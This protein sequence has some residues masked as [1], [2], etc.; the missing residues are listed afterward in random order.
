MKALAMQAK[1][2]VVNTAA[3]VADKAET[4]YL[5]ALYAK[6]FVVNLAKSTAALVNRQHSLLLI[7]H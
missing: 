5:N 1:Q 6:D 7:Q 4:L 2:F 3:K